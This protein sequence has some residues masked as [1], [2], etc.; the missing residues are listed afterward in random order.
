V[1]N[2]VPIWIRA[3][4]LDQLGILVFADAS[5]GNAKGG[6]AQIGHILCTVHKDIHRGVTAACSVIMYKSHKNPSAAPSTLLN[7]STAMSSSLGDAEWV[8]SWIG[9]AKS[10]EYDL[11]K[12]DTLNRDIKIASLF[13]EKPGNELDLGC[14]TDAKSLFDCLVQEQYTG[15]EKRAALEICVIKDSLESLGGRAR[16]L[17]HDRNPADC[18]TKLKGNVEPLLKLLRSGT[19]R[20]TAEEQV[21]A[22]RKSYRELTGKKNPRPNVSV[23]SHHGS[24]SYFSASTVLED[25]NP[26]YGPGYGHFPDIYIYTSE[27]KSSGFDK[28]NML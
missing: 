11:R 25:S 24:T 7:E 1:A 10:L 12:R 16:W 18:L 21:M 13:A 3:I 9:L 8:A 17:P 27:A 5:L 22:D 4:P 20:L 2:D 23:T 14:I 19:F 15:A 28:P 26:G 6:S